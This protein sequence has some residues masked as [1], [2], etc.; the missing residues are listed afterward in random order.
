MTTIDTK[1]RNVIVGC[2]GAALLCIGSLWYAT[3]RLSS[4]ETA[5]AEQTELI[6]K[7]LRRIPSM[8]TFEQ[9]V[10]NQ[11]HHIVHVSVTCRENEELRDCFQRFTAAV[12][13]AAASTT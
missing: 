6:T 4:I 12:A 7:V 11:A 8:T 2:T 13:V 1:L 5:Q 10:E 3:A 9:D